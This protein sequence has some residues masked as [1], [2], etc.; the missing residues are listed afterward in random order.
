MAGRG[1]RVTGGEFGGRRLRAPARGVRPTGDR[2]R[3]SLFARLGDL[4]GARVL[5]LFAG[6]GSLGVEALSRGA[7]RVVFVEQAPS[8]VAVLRANVEALGVGERARVVR[9]D[10]L[11]A[12]RRLA[13]DE[14]GFDLV[15]VDPPYET[16]LA[17]RA[18]AALSEGA[19][20][21]PHGTLVVE[22]GRR[23]PVA[24]GPEWQTLDDWAYGETHVM[25][26]ARAS[27]R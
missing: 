5:D 26:L 24:V 1:L 15:L 21:A 18:L 19:L 22:Y 16:D 20:V 10:A 14:P 12:L 23:H 2:V 27:E 25:R 3:E 8:A 6:S 7:A 17:G 9:S 11:R 4:E 13:G